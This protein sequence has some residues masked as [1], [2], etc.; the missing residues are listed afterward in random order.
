QPII[1][2]RSLHQREIA[3]IVG[4]RVGQNERA[5]VAVELDALSRSEKG[6]AAHLQAAAGARGKRQR[7]RDAR[8]RV[9]AGQVEQATA[10]AANR[11]AEPF[12]I[13]KAVGD[14]I[15]QDASPV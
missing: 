2:A 6:R 14:E 4:S 5:F 8:L 7:Q 3:E 11:S 12:E 15:P 9:A 10:Q 1:A 13:M